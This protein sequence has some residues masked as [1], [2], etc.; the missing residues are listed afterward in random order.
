[1]TFDFV[2]FNTA[3]N[4]LDF[5]AVSQR[6]IRGAEVQLLAADNSVLASGLTSDTGQYSLEVAENTDV[7]VQ[8]NARL[9]QSTGA[10]WDVFV[11]DN[12]NSNA[13]YAI[14]GTI[15]NSGTADS[16]RDLNAP[17]GSNGTTFTS[18]RSSGPFAIL[19]PIYDT[20]RLFEAIDADIV[21]PVA[22]F[23][24]SVNNRP[25]SGNIADGDIGTS[26]YIG[27]GN[28]LILGAADNDTDENDTHVVV[29]EWG[30]YYEDQLS[31]S[32]SV[33]GP[34]GGGDRLDPRVALSEGWGNAVSGIGTNDPVY[35]DSSGSQQA[36][37][38]SFN[39]ENNNNFNDGWFSEGSVQSIIY[40]IFDSENDGADVISAGLAPI[41]EAFLGSIYTDSAFF[42]TR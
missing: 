23:N 15:M 28:I 35:R 37:G 2:P 25:S 14:A 41:H 4:G 17:S 22:R 6:P 31:R 16:T 42:T 9:S 40:D 27:N 24:W 7:R 21:F 8:V 20:L 13:R 19:D 18:A 10:T 3:T 36:Q 29:H 32:D 30:H 38:F 11:Q 34:H 39:V 12:T 5:S 1:M 26:S 33:G